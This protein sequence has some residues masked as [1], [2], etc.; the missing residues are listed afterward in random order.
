MSEKEQ[1]NQHAEEHASGYETSDINVRNIVLLG[2]AIIVFLSVSFVVLNGYFVQSREELVYERVLKSQNPKLQQLREQSQETLYSY[3]V[4]DSAQGVYRI[5][6]DRA[7][8]LVAEDSFNQ[9][10][11]EAGEQ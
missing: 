11:R 10:V 7:M 3:G 8:E 6:I 9:R 2:I 4:V 5:P 1:Q